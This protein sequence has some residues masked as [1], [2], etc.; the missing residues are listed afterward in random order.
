[1]FS[2]LLLSSLLHIT[3]CTVYTVT[4]D[5]HYY[6]NTTCH[7]CHNLQHYLLNV[8]K[9]FTSNTQ[10][11]FLSGLHHLHTNLIIQNVHNISLIGST[12]NGTT[13]DTVTIQCMYPQT[14]CI[15]I[16]N[17]STL[18]IKNLIIELQTQWT[19]INIEDCSYISLDY[20]QIK[21]N[22]LYQ[23]DSN[24]GLICINIMGSS[25][26]N[27]ITIPTFGD[28][29]LFYNE[30]HR[31]LDG[32]HIL[33]LDSCRVRSIIVD[34]LQKS[35]RVI[36]KVTNM[37][38]R[39]YYNNHDIDQM[40]VAKE[41]G[42]NEILIINCQFLLNYYEFHLFSFASSS[43]TYG[44]VKFVN[45]QFQNHGDDIRVHLISPYAR[46]VNPR[47][48]NVHPHVKMEL[49]NCNFHIYGIQIAA[50]LETYNRN[51]TTITT[52]VIIKN[53]SFTLYNIG[54]GMDLT[55][56]DLTTTSFITLSHTILQMEGS[57]VFSNITTPRSII[58]LR[59]N[60][61]VFISGL[62]DFAHNNVHEFINFYENDI[63]YVIMKENSVM[64]I[65]HNEVQKL[66][67]TKPTREKFPYPFCFFQY[68]NNS[69]SSSKVTA[70]NRNYLVKFYNNR[71]KVEEPK[72][73]CF[74]YIPYMYKFSRDINFAVFAVNL[75]SMKFKSS[76]IYKTVVIHLKYKV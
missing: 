30:T 33:T 9:Y 41:L 50:I 54:D 71:C 43:G 56:S 5:D 23:C 51:A 11:L 52:H 39:I 66:F 13:L 49:N 16:T 38:F 62:V 25:Y 8:T 68:F 45:C 53:T 48:I 74:D 58:S 17:V 75:S 28:F 37:Q 15:T 34:M 10:L 24:F 60:S 64:N 63:K 19:L 14:K 61:Q 40:I 2:L 42:T 27:D 3:T 26:F 32:Q 12:A 59:G 6:P 21:P 20:L 22:Q 57:V 44:S 70:E 46:P 1:M 65:I 18:V 69:V 55:S 31:D 7:H 76:K 47:L 4:P 67:A 36:L 73:S 35:Y 72:S 29:K